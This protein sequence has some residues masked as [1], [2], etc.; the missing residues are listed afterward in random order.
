MILQIRNVHIQNLKYILTVIFSPC[1][2]H[3]LLLF[4]GNLSINF[5]HIPSQMV[6]ANIK[7]YLHMSALDTRIHHPDPF[8]W[9][10]LLLQLLGVPSAPFRELS[11]RF[12]Y[13]RP[14]PS[15]GSPYPVTEGA[16]VWGLSHFALMLDMSD[17][18]NL[19]P[20][21]SLGQLRLSGLYC[22]LTSPS[23]QSCFCF[24]P[25]TG[26]ATNSPGFPR[27]EGV[28]RMLDFQC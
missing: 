28:S 1:S 12:A 17:V 14:C 22:S 20:A 4:G 11:C 8:S 26:R 21:L 5:L 15:Q 7:I 16:G 23:I 6:Y 10:D 2:G 9:E 3:P 19:V 25:F 24:L 27:T 13:P 18:P